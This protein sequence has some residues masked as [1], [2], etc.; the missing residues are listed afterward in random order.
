MNTSSRVWRRFFC[1]LGVSKAYTNL[2][3]LIFQRFQIP[4]PPPPTYHFRPIIHIN[5]FISTFLSS[6]STSTNNAWLH[7]FSPLLS[8]SKNNAWL[9][10]YPRYFFST[11]P[12]NQ[13]CKKLIGLEVVGY[14]PLYLFTRR[15]LSLIDLFSYHR[16]SLWS[17]SSFYHYTS[18]PLDSQIKDKETCSK[19][20]VLHT[21][22]F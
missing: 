16:Q 9:H 3:S 7:Q 19:M 2:I 11:W 4:R 18:H 1:L 13:F 5:I 20:N 12:Q 8:T 10:Q 15:F 21:Q 22:H 17:S 14:C 6:L